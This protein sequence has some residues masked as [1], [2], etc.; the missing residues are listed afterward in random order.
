MTRDPNSVDF[1]D[2]NY[3][4]GSTGWDLCEPTPVFKR[5][6]ENGR[7]PPGEMIVLGAGRGYDA[8]LF[9][10]ANFRVTA[11][12]FAD[13]AVKAMQELA[14][15]AAPVEIIQADIFTLPLEMDGR[16]NY[17]L[18][19]TC[20]CAI[21]PARRTEYA[22]LAARLLK[23]GGITIALAFPTSQHTGG[24]PFAVLPDNLI[25]L[26]AGYD[27]QLLHREMPPDSVASRRGREELLVLQ[28][29][30]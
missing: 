19:Y 18:E 24:P 16:F 17:I 29:P 21:D 25:S 28:K 5:L 23:P 26:L 30:V 22:D 8:R 20:F 10:R 14:D 12:D 6:V 7:F 4:N 11:V 15:P 9:A 1:W 13:E 27:F 3:V 2:Q